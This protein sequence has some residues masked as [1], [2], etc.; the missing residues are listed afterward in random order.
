MLVSVTADFAQSD[1]QQSASQTLSRLR[2]EIENPLNI[3][4]RDLQG[5]ADQAFTHRDPTNAALRKAFG[6]QADR[7]LNS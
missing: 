2:A 4:R 6:L 3:L 7:S 1:A 5:A